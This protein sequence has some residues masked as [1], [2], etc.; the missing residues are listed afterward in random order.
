MKQGQPVEF[1]AEACGF[2]RGQACAPGRATPLL[3]T[4]KP[5][6]RGLYLRELPSPPGL[7]VIAFGAWDVPV[8]RCDFRVVAR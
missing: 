1:L 5:G 3:G 8:R 4:V 2:P 7:H 6:Q